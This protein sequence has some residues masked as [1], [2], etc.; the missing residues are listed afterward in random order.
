M[1][2]FVTIRQWLT[3]EQTLK[4]E[5]AELDMAME[6]STSQVAEK[7]KQH[8]YITKELKASALDEV[9]KAKKEKV[10]ADEAEQVVQ[11]L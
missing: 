10:R 4:K 7:A 11:V 2:C 9:E 5:V 6:I 8:E 3:R 1:A